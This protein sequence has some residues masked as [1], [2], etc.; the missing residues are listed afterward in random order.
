MPNKAM[1]GRMP[2]FENFPSMNAFAI[3]QKLGSDCRT[4]SDRF[5]TT[6]SVACQT[7]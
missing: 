7:S 4:T 2:T 6:A 1:T 5:L 3:R